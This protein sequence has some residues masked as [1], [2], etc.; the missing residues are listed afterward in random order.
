M[1]LPLNTVV[2]LKG[3]ANWYESPL[4]S[5]LIGVIMGFALTGIK[6]FLKDKKE[7]NQYEYL[8]LNK[9]KDILN[10]KDEKLEEKID[11]LVD[12]LRVDLRSTKLHSSAIIFDSLLKARE[13]EDYS[14]GLTK[15]NTRLNNL[16]KRSRFFRY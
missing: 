11:D 1:N 2:I 10:I 15:I 7:L 13:G 14:E 16:R 5:G 3:G 6:D 12:E 4:F 9:T 8:L